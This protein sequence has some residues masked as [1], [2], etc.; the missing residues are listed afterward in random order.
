VPAT[1]RVL[2]F[3]DEALFRQR[4]LAQILNPKPKMLKRLRDLMNRDDLCKIYLEGD[5][6]NIWSDAAQEEDLLV[7]SDNEDVDPL[8]KWVEANL[9]DWFYGLCRPDPEVIFQ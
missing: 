7:M 2:I 6:S 5:D 4:E 8:F 1:K 3:E 9:L